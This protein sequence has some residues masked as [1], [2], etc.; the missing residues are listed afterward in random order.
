MIPAPGFWQSP[1]LG[2]LLLSHIGHCQ[3]T[4]LKVNRNGSTEPHGLSGLTHEQAL[5][6]L[7]P[8]EAL[9]T[10]ELPLYPFIGAIEIRARF[11]ISH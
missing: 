4:V 3:T 8:L 5:E 1:R 7:H 11:G 6:S 2:R 10:Y 9:P